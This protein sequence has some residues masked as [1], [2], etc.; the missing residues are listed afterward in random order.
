M[1]LTK[2]ERESFEGMVIYKHLNEFKLVSRKRCRDGKTKLHLVR[3]LDPLR[4][5]FFQRP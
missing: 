2:L 1:R 4:K 3:K 5:V